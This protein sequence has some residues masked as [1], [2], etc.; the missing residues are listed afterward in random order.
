MT[1]TTNVWQPLDHTSL[2][3][4]DNDAGYKIAVFSNGDYSTAEEAESSG[5]LYVVKDTM[6]G[7]SC[8]YDVVAGMQTALECLNGD[9]A[10]VTQLV[11]RLADSST[12]STVNTVMALNVV[13][14]GGGCTA[15]RIEEAAAPGLYVLVADNSCQAPTNPETET[16]LIGVYRDIADADPD[17]F[18]Y[19]S[20]NGRQGLVAWYKDQVGYSPDDDIGGLTP[21]LELIKMVAGS[22]LITANGGLDTTDLKRI[23]TLFPHVG[24]VEST[25][26]RFDC[27]E[28]GDI[29][30][31][32]N[33]RRDGICIT[34]PFL[35]PSGM[36]DVNPIHKYEI[37]L[38]AANMMLSINKARLAKLK[39]VVIKKLENA[40]G[41]F[42][43]EAV[44]AAL[45]AGCLVIQNGINQTDGSIADSFFSDEANKAALKQCFFAY[46]KVEIEAMNNK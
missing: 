35:S 13:Q 2:A 19:M 30:N 29:G 18:P 16:L 25:D 44:E 15:Y 27:T 6:Y 37:P 11:Y 32:V 8:V 3:T 39:P 17:E 14:T 45:N 22:L 31:Y 41:T 10:A 46:F 40:I 23:Q 33:V 43:N 38:A 24:F 9:Y 36:D 20:F 42:L 7:R 34:N 4:L 12:V 21:I 1:T 26:A 28:G 5:G